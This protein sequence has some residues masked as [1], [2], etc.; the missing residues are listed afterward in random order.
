MLSGNE[1]NSKT[2]KKKR[3]FGFLTMELGG[4]YPLMKFID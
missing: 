3:N 1:D 2:I 4:I